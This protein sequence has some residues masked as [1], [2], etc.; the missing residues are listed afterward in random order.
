MHETK[1]RGLR[2]GIVRSNPLNTR[3]ALAP[4]CSPPTPTSL[5]AHTHRSASAS[6]SLAGCAM[7]LLSSTMVALQRRAG[8][9]GGVRLWCGAARG[10]GRQ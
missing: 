2:A 6:I 5:P 8:E 1:S 7:R 9:Q 3:A 10:C 4:H